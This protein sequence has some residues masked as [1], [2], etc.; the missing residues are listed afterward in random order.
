MINK[1]L[2]VINV[3]L[4]VGVVFLI[5][6]IFSYPVIVWCRKGGGK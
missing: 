5:L 2:E 6:L 4:S 1:I 3:F